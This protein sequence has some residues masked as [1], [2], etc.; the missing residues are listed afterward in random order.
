MGLGAGL[1]AGA[2]GGLRGELALDYEAFVGRALPASPDHRLRGTR[3]PLG[4]RAQILRKAVGLAERHLA[5]GT[6]LSGAPLGRCCSLPPLGGPRVRRTFGLP[7]LRGTPRGDGAAHAPGDALPG[8]VGPALASACPHAATSG[9]PL[10]TGLFPT[11]PRGGGGG[12]PLPYAR[13]PPRAPPPS[14]SLAAPQRSRPSGAGS[15]TQGALCLE[16]GAPSCARCR[17]LGWGISRCRRVGHDGHTGP[18]VGPRCPRVPP[19]VAP[20]R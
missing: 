17:S 6:L 7:V 15:G 16:H 8:L 13:R 14:V 2:G 1:D 3:L 9:R 11:P 19:R 20:G 4:E 5:A 10:L 18:S 12:A